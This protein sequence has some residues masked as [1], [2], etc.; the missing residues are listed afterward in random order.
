MSTTPLKRSKT[1][2]TYLASIIGDVAGG[3][4]ETVE[5]EPQFE[6][7]EPRV[8]LAPIPRLTE[9]L[10]QEVGGGLGHERCFHK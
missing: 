4:E 5:G 9:G 10:W 3:V 1:S 8:I 6:L 7:V 2:C